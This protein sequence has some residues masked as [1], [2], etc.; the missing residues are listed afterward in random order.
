MSPA[1]TAGGG[2]RPRWWLP[3]LLCPLLLPACAVESDD[4]AT[5]AQADSHVEL[6]VQE[7]KVEAV[8][9]SRTY[10]GRNRGSREVQVRARVDGIIHRRGYTEGSV[11]E[12]GQKLFQIDPT[13]Y[14]VH[15]QRAEAELE[16]AQAEER[17]AERE[18]RRVSEL[19]EDDAISG[20]ERDAARSELDLAQAGVALAE[21]ELANARLDLDYTTVEAP[22]TGIAGLEE[23]SEG[24]LVDSG[25]LL[26]SITQLDPIQVRFSIPEGHM[27][28]FGSQIQS[29]VGFQVLLTKPNGEAYPEPGRI[30]FTEA[31]IDSATGTV[32]ARAVFANPDRELMPGQFVRITLSELHLGWGVRVPHRAVSE[33][34]DGPQIYVLDDEDKPVA[35][36]LSLDHDLGEYFLVKQGLSEG[37]RLVVDGIASIEDGVVVIPDY[38]EPEA[39]QETPRVLGALPP[40]DG[41]AAGEPSDEALEEDQEPEDRDPDR[42]PEEDE[43]PEDEADNGEEAREESADDEEEN[44]DAQLDNGDNGN[45]EDAGERTDEGAGEEDEP[46]DNN[47]G[48]R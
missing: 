18:W 19:Y 13:R 12:E 37:E 5:E 15:V 42:A 4:E 23:L 46:D 6:P 24:S 2:L 11:V 41:P 35:R 43:S 31:A 22:V 48:D 9:I 30:D 20:R 44:G 10:T 21:A 3:L 25:Q 1:S 29:G 16:R 34:V 33:G 36:Q 17:Q 14:E 8:S 26:T 38:M 39:E 40:A 32:R 7:V 28:A 27:S 47:D 45:G